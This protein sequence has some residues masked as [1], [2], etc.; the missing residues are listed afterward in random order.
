MV[1]RLGKTHVAQGPDSGLASLAWALLVPSGVGRP[2]LG[3]PEK[4]P[5]LPQVIFLPPAV[6][7]D[8]RNSEVNGFSF[9]V[10]QSHVAFFFFYLTVSHWD[11]VEMAGS[12][13]HMS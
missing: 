11:T 4:C 8:R 2:S 13:S 7:E 10:W 3:R 12:Q 6:K 1:G 5:D 9:R